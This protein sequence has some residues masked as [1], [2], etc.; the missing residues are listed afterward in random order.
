MGSTPGPVLH[1]HVET[2]FHTTAHTDRLSASIMCHLASASSRLPT[3]THTP[4]F[5]PL[6]FILDE[7]SKAYSSCNSLNLPNVPKMCTHA[8]GIPRVKI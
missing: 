8:N 3:P 5:Q 6:V 7:A 2:L 1:N 4:A